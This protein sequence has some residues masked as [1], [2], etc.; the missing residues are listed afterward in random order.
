MGG[1]PVDKNLA[2]DD[3]WCHS[4]GMGQVLSGNGCGSGSSA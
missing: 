4:R 2:G 3:R 1:R